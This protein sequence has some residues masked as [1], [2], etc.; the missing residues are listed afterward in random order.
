MS[1]PITCSATTCT[2]NQKGGCYATGIKVDGH[3]ADTT[4]E[5]VCSTYENRES[6]SFSNSSL[7][8]SITQTQDIS[9]AAVKCKYNDSG[10]C[11]A[12]SIHINMDDASCE[13]FANR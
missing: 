8:S 2:Y 12:K 13:T 9:C 6:G 4:R 11:T 5:T 1:N 3:K 7:Q 10:A